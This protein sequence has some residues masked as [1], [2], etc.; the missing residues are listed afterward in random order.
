MKVVAE[1]NL[2][3]KYLVCCRTRL[4]YC[5]TANTGLVYTVRLGRYLYPIFDLYT[6]GRGSVNS[7][8]LVVPRLGR[9]S[10]SLAL[11]SLMPHNITR[12][13]VGGLKIKVR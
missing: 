7:W 4:Y 11:T 10:F 3:Y 8:D 1:I 5:S 2:I 12:V 9:V 13:N 6:I